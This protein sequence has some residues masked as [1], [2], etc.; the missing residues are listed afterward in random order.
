LD[1]TGA[2]TGTATGSA[3]EKEHTFTATDSTKATAASKLT[4]KVALAAGA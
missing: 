4:L 2:I 1:A 3:E